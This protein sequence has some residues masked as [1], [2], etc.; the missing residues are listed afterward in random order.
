MRQVNTYWNAPR[1]IKTYEYRC[2]NGLPIVVSINPATVEFVMTISVNGGKYY[3]EQIDVPYGTAHF[4][5][6][7]LAGNP[8]KV[9]TT[10]GAKDKFTFGN[11]T[12]AGFGPN[13]STGKKYMN[14]YAQ[15]HEDAAD[16]IIDYLT[17]EVDFPLDKIEDYIEKERAIITGEIHRMLKTERDTSI[18]Y[19]KNFWGDT[20][21]EFA[22]ATIGTVESLQTITAD[23]L[24][25]FYAEVFTADN[26]V[27]SIQTSK[28]LTKL[29]KAKLEKLSKLFSDK[30]S[31]LK[32]NAPDL[33]FKFRDGYFHDPDKQGTFVSISY[34]RRDPKDVDYE[35]RVH[36]Y[37][38]RGLLYKMMHDHL[39]EEKH[40][41]YDPDT[42]SDGE[43]FD[44]VGS[45]IVMTCANDNL[46]SVL[47]EIHY[48]L[49]EYWQ[50]FLNSVEGKRWFNHKVS[51][52]IYLTNLNYDDEFA[53][54]IGR[55][56]LRGE[57]Y[58]YDFRK[59]VKV[60]RALTIDKLSQGIKR[61]F[62]LPV[63]IWFKTSLEIEEAKKIFAD[64][65]LAE[66]YKSR[67]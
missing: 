46:R 37:F 17:Y 36:S 16:R 50:K 25:K 55:L 57:D 3:E 6:H 23:H 7:I 5:E 20:Y 10:L 58:E 39:R 63:G 40:L 21:P 14:L 24:R 61:Y 41:I 8:N 2:D 11:K 48:V 64:S 4:L 22:Q 49:T 43:L 67:L 42:F 9:L 34:F 45:G 60:A 47:D 27:I 35:Q 44:Y 1:K 18:Q 33:A 66:L 30:K 19:D 15:G 13:G 31:Q 62:E 51:Q 32:I 29:Q 59:S 52:Y 53:A 26:A 38:I 56:I 28:Q 12:R 65:K 54:T